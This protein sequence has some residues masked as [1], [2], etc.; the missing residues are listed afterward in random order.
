MVWKQF[1]CDVCGKPFKRKN[2]NGLRRLRCSTRCRKKHYRKYLKS[3]Y[4]AHPREKIKRVRKCIICGNNFTPHL[5]QN[6][7]S[8]ECRRKNKNEI[9]Y[10]WVKRHPEKFREVARKSQRKRMKNN[11]QFN[12]ACRLRGRISTAIRTAFTA[13]SI[14]TRR[15]LGCSYN[16]FKRYFEEKFTEGM[17]WE[18]FMQGRIHIDHIKPCA[19]FDLIDPK[20]QLICFHYTNLQPLWAADNLKKSCHLI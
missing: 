1:K 6:K 4:K 16:Y 7:C 19:S 2:P 15:L 3:Y 10:R 5:R 9:V 12:I 18:A 14:S 20:Q 11:I 17:S 13:K 8:E